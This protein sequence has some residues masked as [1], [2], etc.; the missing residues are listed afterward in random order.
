MRRLP[1]A[2]L[3]PA[4]AGGAIAAGLAARL[5]PGGIV[6]SG[7]IWLAALVITGAPLVWSTLRGILR[8]RFAADVVATLAIAAAL[9]LR[10]PLPGLI[11]VLMQSGGE[12]LERFAEGRASR[13]VREL[14]QAAPQ[15]AHR[16]ESGRVADIPVAAISVGDRL[17]VRPGEMIPCDAVVTDGSS[18]L[19]TASITGEPV[20][21]RAEPGTML[22]SGMLNLD[23][24]LTVEATASAGESQYARIVELVRTAQA[25]KAPLQRVADRYAVWF[26]PFTLAVCLTA[27]L[28]SGDPSRILAVL[29]IATPCP[30]ILATPVAI[31]GGF[32]RGARAGIIFRHGGALEQLGRIS[33]AV[34]DKTGTLTV[35][36]PEVSEVIAFDGWS[37]REILRLAGAVER[38]SGHLLARSVV[39]AAES[40][41]TVPTAAEI[42]E[43]PGQGVSGNVEGR[44]VAVGA[45]GYV[46]AEHPDAAPLLPDLGPG[47]RAYVAVDG[48][49][50]G[51]ITYADRMRPELTAL[52]AML[53][54]L[55]IRQT[56]LLSGDT[57]ANA[58][59]VAR[60]AGLDSA[61]GDL[62]PGDKVAEIHRL[63]S[64]GDRVL[65]VGD[66]TNDA[67]A[68]AA[69]TVGMAMAEHGGGV[70]AEAADIVLLR[71]DLSLVATAI[72]I[73]RRT[74][75]IARQ[76]IGV[77]LGLSGAGMLLAAAGRIPP[78]AGAM[79]QEAVDVLVILNALRAS[80]PGRGEAPPRRAT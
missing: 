27:W 33:V 3:L 10:E 4:A 80:R 40:L 50:A 77:G 8:G 25:T 72:G 71:D 68:L 15:I 52:A 36:R 53:H 74:L 42:V 47:L 7:R 37:D 58:D 13:A 2:A 49:G 18:H 64:R 70:T 75:S 38:G 78:T 16:W 44:S 66:G 45:R 23:G 43:S 12:A 34:F 26:T 48:R 62:L 1:P 65:M 46:I 30:L 41:G 28:I 35:G 61:R 14:E 11:I 17:V 57:Q 24:P 5:W 9:I 19:D 60:A 29:V 55:G 22:L 79:L 76:S 73:G 21:R 69:A 6:W 31:L 32:D 39:T 63:L 54:R 67:P 51:A 59:A 56:M 20:P